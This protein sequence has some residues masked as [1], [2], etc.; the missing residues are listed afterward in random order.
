MG[1]ALTLTYVSDTGRTVVFGGPPY[2]LT[3]VSGL[4]GAEVDVHTFTQYL[5]DGATYMASQL[6]PRHIELRGEIWMPG[7]G[8]DKVAARIRLL[9]ALNPKTL[10][11]LVLRRGSFM[12]QLRVAVE[13]APTF[14]QSNGTA[15]A[16][17]LLAPSP[18]WEGTGD[19]AVMIAGLQPEFHWPLVIPERV[20][21]TGGIVFA[22]RN[23]EAPVVVHNPGDV[24]VGF[25]L[26]FEAVRPVASPLLVNYGTGQ[27][28]LV[29]KTLLAGEKLE[30]C[31]SRGEVHVWH[32]V[33]G[34]APANAFD[35]TDT[36]SS[37]TMRLAPGS[38]VFK[39]D[40]TSGKDQLDA[41]MYFRPQYVGV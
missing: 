30:I 37:L 9:E 36:G 11:T 7:H 8:R 16:I 10:G 41:W 39:F 31:T 3:G 26:V 22:N 32:L 15:F 2:L 34:A 40:A 23:T 29:N 28:L 24:A 1:A 6:Q 4:H 5:Q 12:R 19:E 27:Y 33:P 38:N 20:G 14:A 18:L 17:G 25:R 13:T 35:Q 21:I